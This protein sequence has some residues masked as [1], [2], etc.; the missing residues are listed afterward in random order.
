MQI[1]HKYTRAQCRYSFFFSKARD[2]DNPWRTDF[3]V[4]CFRGRIPL[5]RPSIIS[6]LQHT[7]SFECAFVH[8]VTY[9]FILQLFK[10]RP[11]CSPRACSAR[12]FCVCRL[13]VS[14][15]CGI[16]FLFCFLLFNPSA[17]FSLLGAF[18][19]RNLT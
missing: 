14:S 13:R 16:V 15:A 6:H 17:C 4:R 8:D 19:G 11:R 2:H 18:R 7:C 10:V 1:G 5:P 3:G 9:V 12:V